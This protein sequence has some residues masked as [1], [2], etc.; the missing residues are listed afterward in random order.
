[1]RVQSK[2]SCV[3]THAKTARRNHYGDAVRPSPSIR[4]GQPV[5]DDPHPAAAR[6]HNAGATLEVVFVPFAGIG[7]ASPDV[8]RLFNGV[9][10]AIFIVTAPQTLAVAAAQAANPRRPESSVPGNQRRWPLISPFPSRFAPA[11]GGDQ[12]W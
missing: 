8:L 4:Q 11:E 9:Y 5:L 12:G 2:S 10:P 1:M 7:K 3:W 6:D